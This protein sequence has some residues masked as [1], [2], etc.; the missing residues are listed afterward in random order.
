MTDLLPLIVSHE[1][2]PPPRLVRRKAILKGAKR[3]RWFLSLT[4][5]SE[6]DSRWSHKRPWRL[7]AMVMASTLYVGRPW[8][9]HSCGHLR[10][11]LRQIPIRCPAPFVWKCKNTRPDSSPVVGHGTSECRLALPTG[12]CG[13]AAHI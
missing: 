2:Q 13:T 3:S 5:R 9:A 7:A 6:S 1:R 10:L 12:H 4:C 8:V 11:S